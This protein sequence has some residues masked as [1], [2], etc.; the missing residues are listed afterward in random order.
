MEVLIL[1]ILVFLFKM[2]VNSDIEGRPPS[3]SSLWRV[4]SQ[5]IHPTVNDKLPC[6][7]G[8]HELSD[9]EYPKTLEDPFDCF[10]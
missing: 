7:G 10:P 5:Y 6:D 2:Q 1:K 9:V 8:G 4:Y 3:L